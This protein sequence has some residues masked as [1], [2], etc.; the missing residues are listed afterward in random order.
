MAK[1][2]VEEESDSDIDVSSTDSESE[3]TPVQQ[4]PQP[5]QDEEM[6][7][8]VN[9]DFDFFD[10]NPS[11]DF[12]AT[13]NF[14][15]QLLG[16]DSGEFNLSGLADLILTDHSVGTSIKTE[17]VESDPFAL[18]SVVNLSANLTNPVVK[19]LVEY[20][21]GKTKNKTEFNIMLKKLLGADEKKKVKTGL[22]VSERFINMPVEVVPPMYRMLLEEMEKAEDAHESYEFD[23]FLIISR[24]YQ[25]VD[26]VEQ[27][28][29]DS[30]KAKKK[31][32]STSEPKAIE[33]DYFHME[34]QVLEEHAN[35]KGVFEYSN[36]NKQET[37]SR[38]VF[39]EYGIDPKLS[40]ILIDKDNLAKAVVEMANQFPAPQ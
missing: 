10:L 32:I 29:P 12:Q 13:K 40:L 25:L 17:G 27:G 30:G 21:L 20:V 36:E 18:L 34:D 28:D 15:R 37:D 11:V 38:R 19:K 2:K 7:E 16:D 31:K 24:V 5:Q 35:Y 1:R 3:D 6:E 8:T 33:M 9:V 4:P 26:P 22:I 14:L 39:T 23:Y